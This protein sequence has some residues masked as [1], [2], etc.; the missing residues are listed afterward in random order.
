MLSGTFQ[1]VFFPVSAVYEFIQGTFFFRNAP[2][3]MSEFDC[4]KIMKYNIRRNQIENPE[5]GSKKE[6]CYLGWQTPGDPEGEG[7]EGPH[8]PRIIDEPD[9]P[10]TEAASC[11]DDIILQIRHFIA[12]CQ[13]I[14]PIS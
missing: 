3:S 10:I 13:F 6:Q 5:G 2:F 4:F 11:R 7:K 9:V 8:L 12:L 14:M 1:K